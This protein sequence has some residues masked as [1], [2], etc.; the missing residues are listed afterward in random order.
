L[1][2]VEKVGS[3]VELELLV[4]ESDLDEARECIRATA[5]TLGLRHSERRSYLELLPS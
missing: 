4:D 5:E 3:F 1:D 2:N